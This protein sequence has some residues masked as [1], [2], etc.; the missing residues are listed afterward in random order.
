MK[1]CFQIL[2]KSSLTLYPVS[3][4]FTGHSQP[5]I[6]RTFIIPLGATLSKAITKQTTHLIATEADFEKPST[7][8]RQAKGTDIHIVSF[9]WLEECAAKSTKLAED[10]YSLDT[11][12]TATNGGTSVADSKKRAVSSDD[13]SQPAPQPKKKGTNT[14]AQPDSQASS[15]KPDLKMTVSISTVFLGPFAADRSIQ[16]AH[17]HINSTGRFSCIVTN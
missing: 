11:V 17:S 10:L 8:V 4:T 13:D 9:E 2:K 14:K 7:K 6:E 15:S 16:V 12:G 5:S 3:G 1:S